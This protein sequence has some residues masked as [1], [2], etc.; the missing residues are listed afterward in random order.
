MVRTLVGSVLALAG[1]T[2][3]ATGCAGGGTTAAS[4]EPATVTYHVDGYPLD[5][6]LEGL[7]TW[8][9]LQAVVVLSGAER[10]KSVWLTTDGT[11]PAAVDGA[12]SASSDA[13]LALTTPVRG[14]VDAVLFGSEA[15]PDAGTV[16]LPGGTADNVEVT[17][18]TELAPDAA[19]LDRAD[20]LVVAGKVEDTAAGRAIRPAFVYALSEDG[21]TL[22]SLLDSASDDNRPQFTL[23]ELE[24]R[25][26]QRAG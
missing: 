22:T 17:V 4:P 1:V 24:E 11:P 9:D 18:S 16:L 7:A 23:A 20:R 13:A 10:G 25:L 15:G 3:L 6:T 26:R 14:D 2:A 12:D 19:D 8:P 5:R 21:T